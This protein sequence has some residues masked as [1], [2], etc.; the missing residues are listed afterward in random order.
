MRAFKKYPLVVF[1]CA[2]AGLLAACSQTPAVPAPAAAPTSAEIEAESARLN[3]WFEAQFEAELLESPMYLTVLGRKERYDELDDQSIAAQDARL[4]RARAALAELKTSFDRSRLNA[5]ARLSYDL[6]LIQAE[7]GERAASFRDH[8]YHFEQM[9]GIQSFLPTF[10]IN[11]HRVADESDMTAYVSRITATGEVIR[12]VLGQAQDNATAG[13][14]APRFAYEGATEQARAVITGAPFEDSDQ[15]APLWADAK[16]KIAA[17]KL[18]GDA[19]SALT[20]D[21]RAA[22]T[23]EF[24]PAYRELIDWLETDIEQTDAEARGVYALPRGRAYYESRL[25]ANTTTDMTAD[26]IHD[27]GLAEVARLRGEMEA[28]KDR[29]GFEGSLDEFFAFI[30]TDPRFFF[31][32]TDAGRQRYIDEAEAAIDFIRERVPDYFGVLPKAELVV[33]RV[34]PFRERDGAAQHYHPGT[35]DGS[36]PGVYYIHLSDMTAMPTN[37]LEVIAYHEGLPGHHMQ[38]AIS[39][40]MTDL[41]TF[42]RQA[43]FTAYVEGWALY[44]EWLAVEMG[45]YEDPYSDFGRLS[46]EMWRAI[47]LVVDTG[48]HAKGWGMEQAVA[49]AMSNS[50]E[51]EESVR[52]EVRRYFVLPGQATSYKIGMLKIQQLRRDAEAAL[53]DDFDLKGFHDLVLSGGALPLSMLEDQVNAWV[54][55]RG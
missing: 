49:Y 7:R 32:D 27:L 40:E 46:S 1:A 55:A 50:P 52:S 42:R 26:E 2:L 16:A 23:E 36:R 35:P 25:A 38:I 14:R 4:E 21:T 39:Q 43:R 51:P 29:V 45:A 19:A 15:D 8:A 22:L 3:A 5:Q 18:D 31:P 20:A 54:K 28:I 10:L 11:Y 34:E 41:P 33:K 44:S 24:L 9:N 47:R 53:G 13:V 12:T 6:W 17:L 48:L 30:R 37:Q